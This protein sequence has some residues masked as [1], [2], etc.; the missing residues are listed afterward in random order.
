MLGRRIL[1][2]IEENDV[3]STKYM[4]ENQIDLIDINKSFLLTN[5]IN[6]LYH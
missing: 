5:R 2:Y 4:K 6:N 1:F 3:I